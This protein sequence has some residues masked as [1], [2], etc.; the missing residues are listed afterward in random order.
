M[1]CLQLLK[2]ADWLSVQCGLPKSQSAVQTVAIMLT[3]QA[4][5]TAADMFRAKGMAR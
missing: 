2:E 1:T 4:L 5:L 3:S